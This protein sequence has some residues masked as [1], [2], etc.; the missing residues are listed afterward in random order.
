M[1][2]KRREVCQVYSFV[3]VID[4][5]YPCVDMDLNRS[6]QIPPA[7]DNAEAEASV[8]ELLAH[9]KVTRAIHIASR[10]QSSKAYQLLSN[11]YQE[12]G[13]D[14]QEKTFARMADGLRT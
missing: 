13:L 10:S 3:L 2:L 5:R 9:G 14:N 4:G 6:Y 7:I 11:Y 8:A 1:S 12:R